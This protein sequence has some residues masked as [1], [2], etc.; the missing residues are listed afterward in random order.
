VAIQTTDSTRFGLPQGV[1]TI[2]ATVFAMA[3]TDATI[4]LSSSEMTL[5]QIWILRSA[6]VVPILLV[7][8]KGRVCPPGTGWI[9]AR[10]VALVVQYLCYYAVLPLIDMALAGA[11]AYIAPFFIVGLSA[12]V[13]GNRI[14]LRHWLAIATGFAGLLLIVRPFAA[15]FTPLVFLPIAAALFYAIAAILTRV[16]CAETPALILAL[17]LNITCLAFGLAIGAVRGLIVT[18]EWA[19]FIFGPWHSMAGG[20]WGMIL[21]LSVLIIGIAIGL[22]RAYQSP[23]PEVIATFDYS[24]MIFV[25]FWG[26]VFFGEVPDLWTLAGMALISAGGLGVLMIRDS[27]PSRP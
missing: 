20:D 2:V 26:Y 24:Y 18:P 12:L 19:G 4:K 10:G 16:K 13:L 5:W 11:A 25:V 17:W 3:L 27:G 22:A 14:T 1:V 8:T 9:I 7:A 21:V 23:R 15:A 6:I